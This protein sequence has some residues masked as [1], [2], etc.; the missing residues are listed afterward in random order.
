MDE[1]NT[2]WQRFDAWNQRHGYPQ[3]PFSKG[4][5]FWQYAPHNKAPTLHYWQSDIWIGYPQWMVCRKI[6]LVHN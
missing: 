4:I 6:N 1:R 2:N 5:I 3:N